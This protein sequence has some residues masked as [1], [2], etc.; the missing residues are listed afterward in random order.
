MV[1]AGE[2][3]LFTVSHVIAGMWASGSSLLMAKRSP[4]VSTVLTPANCLSSSTAT[5]MMMMAMSEP[6]I[7]LLNF[8]VT[9]ITATLSIPTAALH[10][11]TL[12]K[13]W[14]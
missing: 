10:G 3:R 11:S 12:P 1:M 4:M 2:T 7:F 6:G 8:G 14:A 9:A 5:V 13:Q